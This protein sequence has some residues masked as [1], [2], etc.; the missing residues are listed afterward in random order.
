M[1]TMTDKMV[2]KEIGLQYAKAIYSTAGDELIHNIND[3]GFTPGLYNRRHIGTSG[4]FTIHWMVGGTVLGLYALHDDES[5]NT[6]LQ[7][8]PYKD[9]ACGAIKLTALEDNSAYYCILPTN[10]DNKIADESFNL[11]ENVAFTTQRGRLYISNSELNANGNVIPPFTMFSCVYN[12]TNLIPSTN[13]KI[14]S[15]YLL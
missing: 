2:I 8:Y 5:L 11:T 15:F 14:A 4:S 13:G 6:N 12:I 3:G 10:S 9:Q 1:I 7:V